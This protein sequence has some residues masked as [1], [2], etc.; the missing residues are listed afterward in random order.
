[1]SSSFVLSASPPNEIIH[2]IELANTIAFSINLKPRT[3][4][5]QILVVTVA[6]SPVVC[7]ELV[8]LYYFSNKCNKFLKFLILQY[9]RQNLGSLEIRLRLTDLVEVHHIITLFHS[10]FGMDHEQK[11][12]DEAYIVERIRLLLTMQGWTEGGECSFQEVTFKKQVILG[13]IEKQTGFKSIAETP[14]DA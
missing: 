11:T 1:M 7:K 14:S 3:F 8:S 5:V 12:Q 4:L 10:V 6:H 9:I 13:N 2:L